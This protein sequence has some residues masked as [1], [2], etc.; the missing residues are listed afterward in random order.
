VL[1]NMKNSFNESLQEELPNLWR[2][3]YRLTCSQDFAEDLV[4]R[5]VLRG[6]EKQ[7]QYKIGT[8]LRSWLFSIMHSIW[9]NELRSTMIRKSYAFSVT[10]E[11]AGHYECV[12]ESSKML[13][14]VREQVDLLPEAQRTVLLLV[15]VE[16]YSYKEAAE[17]L[18]VAVGTIMSRLS[19]ARMTIGQHFINDE[20]SAKTI[21]GEKHEN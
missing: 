14:E 15:S 8:Q 7:H 10:Q 3:A 19:R 16:G 6:I 2:F 17:I 11:E 21:T 12:G 18:D 4:Q 20:K 13:Q 1:L 9:K 5:A